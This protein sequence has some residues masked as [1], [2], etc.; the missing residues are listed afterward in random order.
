MH[1][2]I[3]FV[4]FWNDTVHVSGGLSDHHQELENVHTAT[5]IC[6][7]DT[8]DVHRASHSI[9]ICIVKPN[10]CT[11]VSNLSHFGMS[12]YMFRTVFP[13]IIRS[14]RLYI[15]SIFII[16]LFIDIRAVSARLIARMDPKLLIL[17]HLKEKR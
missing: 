5:G 14:S 10:R 11:N 6:Q 9:I 3:K 4:L 13:S 16:T 8:F 15:H 1:Q 2:C 12:R 7:T 17:N